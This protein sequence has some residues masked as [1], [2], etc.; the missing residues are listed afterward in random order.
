MF[1]TN[2]SHSLNDA[3]SRRGLNFRETRHGDRGGAEPVVRELK[4]RTFLFSYCFDNAQGE[5]ADDRV[6]KCALGW[7][8]YLNAV[9]V[10][11]LYG[12]YVYQL[13]ISRLNILIGMDT[14][15]RCSVQSV[16]TAV[17]ELCAYRTL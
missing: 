4:C 16:E 3:C 6:R 7:I 2:G 14:E 17:R 10:I 13:N 11:I 8:T 5:T 15:N 12:S 1:L 9:D